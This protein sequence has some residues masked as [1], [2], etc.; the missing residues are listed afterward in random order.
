MLIK[1]EIQ[2]KGKIYLKTYFYLT[3]L[4][5]LKSNINLYLLSSLSFFVYSSFGRCDKNNDIKF[6]LYSIVTTNIV[7][8]E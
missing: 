5:I 4:K 2:L 7:I 3:K 1:F 8:S 6:I